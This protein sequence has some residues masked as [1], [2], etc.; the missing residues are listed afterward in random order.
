MIRLVIAED[1]TL[2]RGALAAVL[3]LEPDMDVVA[4]AHDGEEALAQVETHMPDL[5]LTDIEMP[6]LSGI[7]LAAKVRERMGDTVRIMIVTTFARPGYLRRALE[8]GVTGYVLK[9]SPSD[10]LAAAIRT[11]AQ[12]GRAIAPELA[13]AAWSTP[14]PLTGRERDVLR[15]AEAGRTNKDIAQA[16]GLSAGTVRNYLASAGE[17]LGAANRIEAARTAR[18]N[19]WL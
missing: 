10:D 12:G 3:A 1:Q 15:L 4:E 16:L 17:K 18:E 11:V 8:A 2:L 13:Q 7:D 9:D 19:G 14:D 5:L 6:R